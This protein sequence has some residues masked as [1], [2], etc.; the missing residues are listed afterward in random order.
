MR[1]MLWKRAPEFGQLAELD[2]AK[3]F[4]LDDYG[5]DHL[6][7]GDGVMLGKLLVT[8]GTMVR[9][10][11]GATARAHY[12]RHGVSTLIGHTHRLGSYFRTNLDGPHAAFEGGC[13]CKLSPEYVKSPDWQQGFS[14]VHVDEKTGLFNV[15]LIPILERRQFFYG[16]EQIKVKGK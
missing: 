5:F 14:V 15:Q 13:L 11:S 8:H 6:G 2:F 4:H 10:H 3:L 12:D 1:R 9:S 7:Y 16:G